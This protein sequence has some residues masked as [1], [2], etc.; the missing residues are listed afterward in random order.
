MLINDTDVADFGAVLLDFNAENSEIENSDNF[1]APDAL[2]PFP[3]IQ[4][5]RWGTANAEFLVEQVS[6]NE[7]EKAISRLINLAKDAELKIE[8]RSLHYKGILTSTEKERISP[9][10][11]SL[12]IEWQCELPYEDEISEE[13]SG[14][15]SIVL[16]CTGKTPAILE[17]TPS[18]D[19]SQATITGL[20]EDI[21]LANLT[22]GQTVIIDGEKGLV[23]E[24]DQ[25]KWADYDSWGFPQL[26][27][28]ENRITVDADLDITIRYKP[29]WI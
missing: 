8:G 14:S 25:N 16:D 6:D 4:K 22:A 12:T 1:W 10:H 9:G 20:G 11:Y 18:S 5:V 17:L 24:N 19:I 21:T 13:I 2:T 15:G 26:K 23:T 27:P 29:R 7:A 3:V 28:G